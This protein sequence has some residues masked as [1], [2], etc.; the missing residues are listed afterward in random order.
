[1]RKA[2]QNKAFLQSEN[3]SAH[4][5]DDWKLARDN[6]QYVGSWVWC[7]WDY[8]GEAG[9]GTPLLGR[10][11][12]EIGPRAYDPITGKIP[13]PWY[14]S[15]MGDIDLIG[16]RKPQNYYRHVVEGLSP[17]EM[18]VERPI[19]GG[20]KSFNLGYSWF[21]ELESWTWDVPAGQPML[22]RVYSSG[23]SVALLLNGRKIG[24]MSLVETDKRIAVFN[25]PYAPGEL[26]AVA[27]KGGKQIARKTLV[28]TGK[29]AA[30][31]L[32]PDV[33]SLTTGRADLAHVLVE[34]VDDRGRIVPDA[35]LKVDFAVEGAGELAGVANGNPHNVDSFKRPR[36]WTWHGQALAILR[37]GRETGWLTLT[38]KTAGLKP[39]RLNLQV[40]AAKHEAT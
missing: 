22:V 8:M 37:P 39:A 23:D 35:M 19:P 26:V 32:T 28:T 40:A 30:L 29:P 15:G 20:L 7:G 5:Y 3:T 4:I 14:V 27:S 33:P 11:L 38:A 12:K 21:D 31:R 24:A 16:Q 36:R 34:V 6:A 18:M 13:Y 25:V 17:L 10:S 1:V 2:H 9:S